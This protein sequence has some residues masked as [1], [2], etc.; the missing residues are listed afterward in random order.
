[1]ALRLS[2]RKLAKYYSDSLIKGIDKDSVL[3]QLASYMIENGRKNE[4]NQLIEEIEYQLS[5]RGIITA[6]VTS[7]S[8]LNESVKNNISKIISNH[9]NTE[10]VQL[11]EIINS[12][13]IGG[14]KLEYNGFQI[15]NTIAKKILKLKTI[16]KENNL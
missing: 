10:N 11:K 4:V 16:N 8:K 15:D 2:R 13:V 1:M 6:T 5:L 14:Y 3:K 9:T 7:A 12:D